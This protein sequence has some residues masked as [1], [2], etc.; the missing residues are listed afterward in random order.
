MTTREFTAVIEHD[1]DMYIGWVEEVPGANTQADS[2]EEVLSNLAEALEMVI[3]ARREIDQR[4]AAGQSSSLKN[5]QRSGY[6]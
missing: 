5:L 2:V 6:S 1:D 4:E 3:T